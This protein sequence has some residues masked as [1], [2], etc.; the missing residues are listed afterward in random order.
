M[1]EIKYGL[2]GEKIGYS[3][4]PLIYEFLGLDYK[5]IDDYLNLNI[6]NLNNISDNNLLRSIILSCTNPNDY[7]KQC[8]DETDFNYHEREEP[9][10]IKN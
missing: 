9:K 4:S 6:L 2:L 10:I 7:F 8:R 1:D 3:Y 5:L